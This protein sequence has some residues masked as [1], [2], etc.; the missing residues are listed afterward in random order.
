[1]LVHQ[2]KHAL[3]QRGAQVGKS[4]QIGGGMGLPRTDGERNEA[5]FA[6]VGGAHHGARLDW[7]AGMG[8]A[9]ARRSAV[10]VLSGV[11]WLQRKMHS[12]RNSVLV[13]R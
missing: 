3:R 9:G 12:A 4:V 11:N 2:F 1:M 8:G 5:A 10:H 6:P 13:N 7:L